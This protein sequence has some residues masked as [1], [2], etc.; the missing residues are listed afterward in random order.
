LRQ[1][2]V[3]TTDRAR[4]LAARVRYL[5]DWQI[6]RRLRIERAR[7]HRAG[8]AD[9][10]FFGVTGSAGK[11][12]TAAMIV[13]I[14]KTA[15]RVSHAGGGG[16]QLH[17][18]ARVIGATQRTDDFCVLEFGAGLPE[19]FDAL[20]SL[21]KPSIA[22]V[23]TVGSDH[24]KVYGSVD[25]IAEEKGK[26][27]AG[28]PSDGSAVLNADDPRVWAM[29]DLFHGHI[30]G[31]GLGEGAELRASDIRAN[32][33]ER[34][35]FTVRYRDEE[36]RVRTQLCG[37]HWVTA[38]CAA[39]AAGIAAGV[40]LVRAVEAV[41][42]VP[43]AR[44]RMQPLTTPD[45]IT[46][47]RDDWKGAYWGMK[48]VLEFLREAKARRKILV[49]GTLADYSGSTRARYE[50]VARDGLAV[51][52]AVVFVGNM[53]TY[54]LRALKFAR[55]D[56]TLLAFPG[57][58]QAAEALQEILQPGDLVVLR[59]SGPADHLGRLYHVRTGPVTCWRMDCGKM[60]LCEGC[61][62]LRRRAEEVQMVTEETRDETAVESRP[63]RVLVGIGN[64][65][66]RYHDTPHNAGFAV[67]DLVA[68]RHGLDWKACGQAQ[69][70]WLSKGGSDILLVKPQNHVNRTGE[71]LRVLAQSMGFTSDC[72]M[73]VHDDIQMQLGKVRTRLRGSDGGHKG[74]RSVLVAFQ[75]SELGR[76]K[77]GVA[78]EGKGC[79]AE[80]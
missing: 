59:G 37:K 70:A 79:A 52:D 38:V 20:V 58:R 7:I 63:D 76:V 64:P 71:V 4:A 66:K 31:F 2:G 77:V 28:L 75:T 22:V 8:L 56:Q 53:A 1:L 43:P 11:T 39:L 50:E 49:L 14:L 51:A 72:C 74:V 65:G 69:I 24:L 62:L 18:F 9:V 29:R 40:P 78:P 19:G 54:G 16:N 17:H 44:A 12:T 21:A 5:I 57:V 34:L 33:P 67:L 23:T 61:A 42:L 41:S 30:I 80:D 36:Y 26:L 47:V 6:L 25:A 46:F 55:K 68:E 3:R 32:W 15:G 10:T 13:E 27:V 45:G 48:A 60:T 35:S 73:L